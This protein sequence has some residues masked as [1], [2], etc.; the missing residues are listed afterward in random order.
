MYTH[1]YYILYSS[2]VPVQLVEGATLY[3]QVVVSSPA[4]VIEM[5]FKKITFYCPS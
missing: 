3:L 1:T 2:G 4:L 5:T